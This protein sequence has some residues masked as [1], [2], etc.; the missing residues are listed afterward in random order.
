MAAAAPDGAYGWYGT[1]R[2]SDSR[3]SGRGAPAAT[4]WGRD[5]ASCGAARGRGGR[6]DGSRY[7]KAAQREA[8]AGSRPGAPCTAGSP[9][10]HP[11]RA[12]LVVDARSP[13][14]PPE[15]SSSPRVPQPPPPPNPIIPHAYACS[16][17][18]FG[19]GARSSRAAAPAGGRR[20][21]GRRPP[22]LRVWVSVYDGHPRRLGAVQAGGVPLLGV[23]PVP[24]QRPRASAHGLARDPQSCRWRGGGGY[25][26]VQGERRVAVRGRSVG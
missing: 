10:P 15:G 18:V 22:S 12:S 21:P 9:R 7:G 26:L 6:S 8:A 4:T 1:P 11:H 14:P 5:G 23:H 24:H 3:R 19:G 2:L 13:C 20:R 16:P 17:V 25:P